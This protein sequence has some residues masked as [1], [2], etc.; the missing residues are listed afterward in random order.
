MRAAA[1]VQLVVDLCSCFKHLM[2]VGLHGVGKSTVSWQ[3]LIPGL[4]TRS[5]TLS[6]P[7]LPV[8]LCVRATTA[9][10]AF[11]KKHPE[12]IFEVIGSQPPLHELDVLEA[13]KLVV[14]IPEL[15][16]IDDALADAGYNRR[17]VALMRILLRSGVKVKF[18]TPEDTVEVSIAR[19]PAELPFT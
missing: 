3:A 1:F 4:V 16:Y 12:T 18:A 7:A 17:S 10:A 19:M 11:S 15:L 8:L 5:K 6:T 13:A 2:R 14:Q 9:R